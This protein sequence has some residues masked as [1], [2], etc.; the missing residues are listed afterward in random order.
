MVKSMT[1]YGIAEFISE[2]Y[3]LKVE[4]KALNGK[5]LDFNLKVPKELSEKENVIKKSIGDILV[6]GKLNIS[7]D[8]TI[9]KYTEP[10]VQINHDLFNLYS[11]QY[12][13]LA[14]GKVSEEEVFKL[15]L[16]S[17]NVMV[18]KNDISAVIDDKILLDTITSAANNCDRFRSDEGSKLH[19]S[20]TEN[21][22]DIRVGLH[23]IDHLDD[24]RKNAVRSRLRQ[25][26][27]DLKDKIQI[28][29]NR[30]E[31]ELIYYIERLDISE[32][33][34]RLSSHLDYFD[35][36]LSKKEAVGKTL[37]FIAQEIGREINTIGSKANDAKLQKTVVQMK[38]A[39]EQIKEQA[40]NVL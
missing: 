4:I 27:D 12:Q 35:E 7:I 24:Q 3:I 26:I 11:Q 37:G 31:Q 15:S 8:L 30:F 39:L 36:I 10:P 29:E 6:R 33:K 5:Y 25:G 13:K 32:E 38:D 22:R 17:P 14:A 1:G 21:I 9:H 34:V 16:Q 40:M 20:L 28:D 2:G 19:K 23:E 18:V